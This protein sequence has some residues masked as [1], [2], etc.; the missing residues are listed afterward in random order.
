[1]VRKGLA[2]NMTR[3]YGEEASA[4]FAGFSCAAGVGATD[5]SLTDLKGVLLCIWRKGAFSG[6]GGS[7]HCETDASPGLTSAADLAVWWSVGETLR[8]SRPGAEEALHKPLN[9]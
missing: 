9:G 3:C 6:G 2:S 7:Y 1:M 5:S 4:Y 8:R